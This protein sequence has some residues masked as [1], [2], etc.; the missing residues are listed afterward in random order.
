VRSRFPEKLPF[1][2]IDQVNERPHIVVD[3]APK[4][5]CVLV[6]SHWPGS[7]T[8]RVLMRDLSAEI[9][10]AY[11]ERRRYW[12]IDARAVTNDHFDEDGLASVFAITEP[13]RAFD[14]QKRL[15]AFARAGDF[16]VVDDLRT[17]RSVLVVRALADPM[18]SPFGSD[19]ASSAS[20]GATWVAQCYEELSP[21][22]P[23]FLEAPE[24]FMDLIEDEEARYVASREAVEDGRVGIEEHGG[25][26]LA[27]V[28][29]PES[30]HTASTLNFAHNK[31]LSMHPW[32]I[33]S[34]TSQPRI[35][36]IKGGQFC[37]YDRYETWVR[38][39]SRRLLKRRNLVALAEHL[40]AEECD[41]AS[42]HADGPG[43]LVPVCAPEFGAESSL[44][45]LRVLEILG[46]YLIDASVAWD[47]SRAPSTPGASS[48]GK[49][50][51]LS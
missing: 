6:L 18:R 2:G 21:R 1:V 12:A 44:D 26:G 39:T 5:G 40:S 15:V 32:A 8:P 37:Y 7:L 35:F 34:A 47:P 30:L 41:G 46:R 36:V 38:F 10:F 31:M 14:G 45:P 23:E 4:K 49:A 42:W 9:V 28:R 43:D 51:S 24:R 50:N 19:P 16:G 25:L 48:G 33:H 3:G 17:A 13:V 22:L 27:V 29:V 11:L 20:G